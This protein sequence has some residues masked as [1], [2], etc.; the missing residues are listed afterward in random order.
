MGC[1]PRKGPNQLLSLVQSCVSVCCVRRVSIC[2]S[3]CQCVL[4]CVYPMRPQNISWLESHHPI[5]HR[6][7]VA[8]SQGCAKGSWELT[9][10][11]QRQ[12]RP[13]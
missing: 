5:N 12:I 4:W 3:V 10:Q 9:R 2:D 1:T 13:M 7:G 6:V 11:M 8:S